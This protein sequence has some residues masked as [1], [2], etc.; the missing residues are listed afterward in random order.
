MRKANG[1]RCVGPGCPACYAN[2]KG[3]SN[4]KGHRGYR[5]VYHRSFYYGGSQW[6]KRPK[7]VT[8]SKGKWTCGDLSFATKYP[9]LAA[10]LC[11]CWWDDGSPRQCSSLSVRMDATS[12]F[13]SLS[14]HA[15]QQSAFTQ[16]A[17]LEEA[18]LLLEEAVTNSTIQFRPW[19]TGSK[20]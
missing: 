6:M 12:C 18:L 15:H 9:S 16:A 20:K 5:P 3:R 13:V 8:A 4:F 19:K 2:R 17:S 7:A 1:L 10:M 14:D 11:D